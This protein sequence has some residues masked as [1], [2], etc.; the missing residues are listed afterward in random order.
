MEVR[1]KVLQ[2]F[3]LF[4]I[5]GILIAIVQLG[6][7]GSLTGKVVASQGEEILG[8]FIDHIDIKAL[9]IVLTI[10]IVFYLAMSSFFAHRNR[11]S[12]NWSSGRNLI[13]IEPDNNFK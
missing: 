8:D 7:F 11:L 10:T 1:S 12:A 2:G 13:K 6:H 9:F 5:L 4:L 3:A